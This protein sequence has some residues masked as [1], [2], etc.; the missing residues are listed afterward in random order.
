MGE[1]IAMHGWGSDST[2]WQ[3]WERYFL[4]TGWQWFNGERGYGNLPPNNPSWTKKYSSQVSPKRV[5]IGH[6][7][8][9]HLLSKEIL[10]KATHIIFLGS[11][12]RFIPKRQDNK[13]L[14]ATLK[15]MRNS[16]GSSNEEKML[17]NFLIKTLQP[18]SLEDA[19]HMPTLIELSNNGRERMRDDLDKLINTNCLPLGVMPKV[20]ALVI[21]AD[22]DNIVLEAA[23]SS[24]IEDLEDFL[25]APPTIWKVSNAGHA[26]INEEIIEKVA[27]WLHH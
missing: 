12:A 24:L 15:K 6:S 13:L 17:N 26:L 11:F 16:L 23:K 4:K 5:I 22:K 27:I 3:P 19:S 20:K 18:Q 1:I 14:I 2:Y 9:P 10:S 21:E 8:G 7:L 25:L